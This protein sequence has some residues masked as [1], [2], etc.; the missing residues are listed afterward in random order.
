MLT[1]LRS[2]DTMLTH[3]QLDE[4]PDDFSLLT[5]LTKLR[6]DS[7][8]IDEMPESMCLRTNMKSLALDRNN[9]QVRLSA[10]LSFPLS[11]SH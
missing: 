11:L 6:L 2:A 9:L 8:N 10:S 1:H 5:A 3:L 7:N 4:I